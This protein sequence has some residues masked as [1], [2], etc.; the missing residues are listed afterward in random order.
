[1]LKWRY[2]ST[3]YML[4]TFL[5]VSGK[6]DASATFLQWKRPQFPFDGTLWAPRAV[7]TLWRRKNVC[8]YRESN[9]ESPVT[10]TVKLPLHWLSY[11]ELFYFAYAEKNYWTSHIHF[12]PLNTELNRTRRVSTLCHSISY[13]WETRCLCRSVEQHNAINPLNTE[14]NPICQ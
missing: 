7:W 4:G 5:D 3:R 11:P 12:N 10:Q 2:S 8:P 14:L 13:R 1:M 6:L 9:F